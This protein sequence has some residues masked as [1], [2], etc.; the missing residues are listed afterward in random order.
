MEKTTN[1]YNQFIF[2]VGSGASGLLFNA[3]LKDQYAFTPILKS[4]IFEKKIIKIKITSCF[5]IAEDEN[6]NIY[7]WGEIDT[8]ESKKV[9]VINNQ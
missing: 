4:K 9:R 8:N 1:D 3:D 6:G 2:V 7:H 5:G